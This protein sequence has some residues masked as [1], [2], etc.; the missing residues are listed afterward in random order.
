MRRLLILFRRGIAEKQ[1]DKEL[2]FHLEQQ[3]KS[4][5][6][7]GMTPEEARR[8][9]RLD[10]GGLEQIKEDCRDVRPA[11]WIDDIGRDLRFSAQMMR[12][13]PGFTLLAVLTLGAALAVAAVM[14]SIVD[15]VLLKPLPFDN[16]DL[17]VRLTPRG[18]FSSS[19]FV[20]SVKASQS[21]DTIV[22]VTDRSGILAGRSY[23]ERINATEVTPG[24]FT[25]FGAKLVLGRGLDETA[26]A[27]SAGS[28]VVL[29]EALWK[30]RY[31][32]D[33]SLIGQSVTIDGRP[34]T[35]VGV[36]GAVY[37]STPF[38]EMFSNS[39]CWLPR[40]LD[41]EALDLFSVFWV[42]HMAKGTT[43]KQ[44]QAEMD[45]IV[46]RANKALAGPIPPS[47][48]IASLQE[49]M[50]ENVR[51][52]IWILFLAVISVLLIAA[53]NIAAVLL[54]RAALRR[55]EMA[56][57]SA[58][59]ASRWRIIRQLLTEGVLLCMLAGAFGLLLAALS[60]DAITSAA[61]PLF[62]P[63]V[64]EIELDL[65]TFGFTLLSALL[66]GLL[67]AIIPSLRAT[68]GHMAEA[69]SEGALVPGGRNRGRLGKG[70]VSAQIALALMLLVVAGLA[71][72]TY[73]RS[74]WGG[75]GY[76]PSNVLMVN[77]RPPAYKAE[78]RGPNSRAAYARFYESVLERF[79]RIP[80]VEHIAMGPFRGNVIGRFEIDGR[81]QSISVAAPTQDYFQLLRIPLISGRLLQSSDSAD[82]PPV[83]VINQ[84][85]AQK[86][87][88][89]ADPVGRRI[90][91]VP[92]GKA[93]IRRQIQIVG[94]V[95]DMRKSGDEITSAVVYVPKAQAEN[96]PVSE[97]M[98]VRS[99]LNLENLMTE[100]RT[101]LQECDKDASFGEIITVKQYVAH[102]YSARTFSLFLITLFGGLAFVL[103]TI[104]IYGTIAYSVSRR[105][106]EIGIRM[107][108][109]AQRIHVLKLILK[110]GL[111]MLLIGE[112]VGLAGTLILSRLLSRGLLAFFLGIDE[113]DVFAVLVVSL[114]WAVVSVVACCIPALR[115]TRI[116]PLQALR[117]E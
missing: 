49:M 17:L 5:I 67:C 98:L 104:G 105:T 85:T 83:A 54:S 115:A 24:F 59:G 3:L 28:E 20:D 26:A 107:A 93:G 46:R 74:V 108:V 33:K 9:A 110:Q 103:A 70:L 21:I 10:F 37:C 23:P 4:Y 65:R 64:N 71:I 12:R 109:G 57:R 66:I 88:P 29:N 13:S 56:I 51:R 39:D 100:L 36:L 82:A 41:P 40:P 97:E 60:K 1:L 75:L 62:L 55:K 31:G 73:A 14:F 86:F 111:A 38:E 77:P 47:I 80:G 113:F 18:R 11:R 94:V 42:G 6:A 87:W 112:I 53:A 117:Y 35:V 25:L 2:G 16:P 45:V 92:R 15:G 90:S 30:R 84:T 99:K 61:P 44:A 32:G 81:R 63:P 101:A 114:S 34:Y 78:Y 96:Q 72:R 91:T 8:K 106:H 19:E 7:S 89:G 79:R 43:L 116:D 76:D 50:V 48:K 52:P 102:L 95:G 27:S 69:L 58:S 22:A 68:E